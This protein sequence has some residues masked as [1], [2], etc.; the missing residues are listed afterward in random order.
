M[1]KEEQF[2]K[3]KELDNEVNRIDKVLSDQCMKEIQPFLD[4]KEYQKAKDYA[5]NFYRTSIA[6]N[7]YFES[8]NKDLIFHHINLLM[9]EEK[10]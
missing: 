6:E 8:L 3:Y 5:H 2:K 7:G 4:K 9:K 1:K 10:C